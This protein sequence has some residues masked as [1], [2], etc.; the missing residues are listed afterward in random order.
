[1]SEVAS[2]TAWVAFLRRGYQFRDIAVQLSESPIKGRQP[3][4]VGA[5]QLHKVGSGHLPVADDAGR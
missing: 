5:G 2:G 4:V 3:T 1:V